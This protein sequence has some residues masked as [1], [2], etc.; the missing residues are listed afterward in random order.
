MSEDYNANKYTNTTWNWN[1]YPITP[2]YF[3]TSCPNTNFNFFGGWKIFGDSDSLSK[4]I[5]MNDRNLFS[6]FQ[7]S[8]DKFKFI[9][10][11]NYEIEITVV[12]AN[13][14][15]SILLQIMPMSV[16]TPLDLPM[17]STNIQYCANDKAV[18]YTTEYYKYSSLSDKA[19]L[20]NITLVMPA[21]PS[22]IYNNFGVSAFKFSV[23]VCFKTCATCT[24]PGFDA[25]QTC[26]DP[27]ASLNNG[28]CSCNSGFA[29]DSFDISYPCVRNLFHNCS[30][31]L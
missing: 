6:Q 11:V 30:Y 27:N 21:N 20:A 4:I 26:V 3:R 8:E 24:S 1:G 31:I 22:R 10:I 28:Q 19:T 25:C 29:R 18:A 2:Y 13:W 23:S 14:D 9:S 17:S 12:F 5:K 16:S 15:N 7:T